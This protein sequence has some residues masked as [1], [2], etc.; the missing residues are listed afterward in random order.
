VKDVVLEA[1]LTTI[2]DC[3]DSVAAVDAED[4]ALAYLE[5]SFEKGGRTMTRSLNADRV[6][7]AP[8]GGE[9]VLP[10]RSLMF[11]RNVGHLMTNPAIL[12]GNGA[13]IRA[14][15]EQGRGRCA[16]FPRGQ[17]LHRKAEDARPR[18]GGLHL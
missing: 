13:E 4:K 11:V 1:A 10:G 5:D 9:L 7:T 8:D 18:R 14:R 16:Q 6:F 12:D 15:P 3:E 2:Q 17:C